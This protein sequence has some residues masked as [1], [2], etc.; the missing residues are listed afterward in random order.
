MPQRTAH[1]STARA[2]RTLATTALSALCVS[3]SALPGCNGDA[4]NLGADDPS[5]GATEASSCGADLSAVSLFAT[6][7]AQIEA[8]RGCRELPGNLYINA[9]EDGSEPLSL[10]PLSELEAVHGLLSLEGPIPSLAGLEALEQVAALHLSYLSVADLTP[11]RG[12]TTVVRERNYARLSGVLRI[13]SCHGLTALRTAEYI[14]ISLNSA[15]ID[16]DGLSELRAVGSLMIDG[17]ASL[18]RIDLPLLD[19]FDSIHIIDN[20]VLETV[21]RYT[22]STGEFPQPLRAGEGRPFPRSSRQI[23]EVSDNPRLTSVVTPTAFT[24]IDQIVVSGNAN[25]I[26]LDMVNLE[27]SRSIWINDN[28]LL[29]SVSAGFLRRVPTWW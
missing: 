4:L 3:A 19:D 14:G 27:Q 7:Q 2:R 25:L 16:L 11:L 20:A 13:E 12:L 8:L 15:L 29:A 9:P 18:R 28:P 24:D 17:N 22:A 23:F 5:A 21:P 10:E 1:S 6:T 26:S